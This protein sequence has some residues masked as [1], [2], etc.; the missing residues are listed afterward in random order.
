LWLVKRASQLGSMQ[1][2]SWLVARSNNNLL[3][4]S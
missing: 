4:K 2:A 3:I 1:L